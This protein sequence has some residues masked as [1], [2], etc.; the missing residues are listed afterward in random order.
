MREKN[1]RHTHLAGE[2][3]VIVYTFA[4]GRE[5]AREERVRVREKEM[6][7]NDG[8]FLTLQC[9]RCIDRKREEKKEDCERNIV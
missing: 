3:I 9:A 5:R 7:Y 1:H 4:K 6:R 2:V 8:S